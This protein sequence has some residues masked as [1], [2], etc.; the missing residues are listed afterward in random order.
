MFKNSSDDISPR[1]NLS[2]WSPGTGKSMGFLSAALFS[3][4]TRKDIY[5]EDS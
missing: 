1:G 3:V 5:K 2:F 4:T